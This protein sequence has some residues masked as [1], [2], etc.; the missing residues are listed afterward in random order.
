[1]LRGLVA[2]VVALV[3]AATLIGLLDRLVWV[4]EPVDTLRLQYV[5]VLL[6]GA[7]AA[8]LLRRPR[9]AG[10]AAALAAV[11]VALLW[12][13][14]GGTPASRAGTGS[15]RVVTANVEVG[16][17]H[18]HAVERL[19][20]ETKPELFGVI[21]LTPEMTDHLRAA[22]PQY[23]VRV[24][25]PRDD[26]YGIGVFSRVALMSA[27]VVRLP[28]DAGPPAVV[29]RLRVAG[30]P[31]T[32]V[33]VHIRTPFAGSIHVRQLHAL[34][35]A[36]SRVGGGVAI[37]GDFNT[38]PWS[39]PLRDFASDAHLSDL[40]GHA[41][42]RAYSWPTWSWALRVPI[43]NCFVSD[44]LVVRDHRRGPD[45]GSDHFPLVVDLAVA[46]RSPRARAAA[47][48]PSSARIT[49]SAPAR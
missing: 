49:R 28:A 41:A 33:V 12:V 22:L 1:M 47:R 21:E 31:M 36:R 4:F 25:A 45:V 11:N 48:Q 43:D 39:G 8:I 38:P 15:L 23:R 44:G 2:G 29:V 3:G 18:F 9:L 13:L 6:A 7:L 34:A 5:V 35:E 40:Y 10:L 27:R 20:A 37:C 32:V 16:N 17:T 24:L 42:W 19:V 26:A 14:T 30:K 46:G